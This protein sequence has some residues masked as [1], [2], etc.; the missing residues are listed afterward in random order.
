MNKNEVDMAI[1]TQEINSGQTDADSV[2]FNDLL[3]SV[4]ASFE[5][6]I[7]E[8]EEAASIF[9]S[10]AT[11][12][13]KNETFKKIEEDFKLGALGEYVVGNE[14]ALPFL[15]TVMSHIHHKIDEV[16][17]PESENQP[18]KMTHMMTRFWEELE[19]KMGASEETRSIVDEIAEKV[20]QVAENLEA[21]NPAFA[22]SLSEIGVCIKESWTNL[23][24]DVE[25][26]I[27]RARKR[28][29][30]IKSMEKIYSRMIC[31]GIST[32]RTIQQK[33]E[34]IKTRHDL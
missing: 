10:A 8:D 28:K 21:E 33:I 30:R 12:I 16:S 13:S 34:S 18:R 32:A 14:E 25:R 29:Y 4:W 11:A 24:N 19:L 20:S 31:K 23:R 17:Q 6:Q 9:K 2:Q 7:C 3:K 26:C 27:R 5:N 22:L 15:A 1:E